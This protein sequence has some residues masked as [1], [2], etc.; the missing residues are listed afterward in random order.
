MFPVKFPLGRSGSPFKSID[1]FLNT[2][3]VIQQ[4]YSFH[5]CVICNFDNNVVQNLAAVIDNI[6]QDRASSSMCSQPH[7][8]LPN[9]T[10][11]QDLCL[12]L[13]MEIP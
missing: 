8:I 5:F 13:L 12:Q 9:C 6:R 3:S 1:I 7:I 11:I 4:I 2:G 10:H